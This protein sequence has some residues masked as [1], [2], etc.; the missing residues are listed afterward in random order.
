MRGAVVCSNQIAAEVGA[1]IIRRGGN[2]VDSAIATALSLCVVDPANCGVGG[3]GGYMLVQGGQG[4]SPQVVD[5]NAQV[6]KNFKST[7]L[8]SN[9]HI[10]NSIGGA[11]SVSMP[12]V[13]SGLKRAHEE[14]GSMPFKE[15]C[16]KP[17]EIARDGFVIGENLNMALRWAEGRDSEFSESFKLIFAPRGEWLTLGDVLV[18]SDLSKTLEKIQIQLDDYFY[19]GEFA[20]QTSKYIQQQGGWLELEHFNSFASKTYSAHQFSFDEYHIYGPPPITSGYG[21]VCDALDFLSKDDDLFENE[22][23]YIFKVSESL[24]YG[25]EKKK[26]IF[27]TTSNDVTQHTTHFCVSDLSGMM[28]SCTF[29][30][31]PLWFGSGMITPGTGVVLNCA[32][33]LFRKE[34]TSGQWLCVTNL[35]PNIMHGEEGA[36]LA[37]GAP[38]GLRIPAIVL[39]IILEMTKGGGNLLKAINKKRVSVSPI[40]ELELEDMNLAKIHHAHRIF[41]EEYFGPSSAILRRGNGDIYVGT[42]DRFKSGVA[43]I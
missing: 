13:L 43:V 7:L 25:W 28:V 33:N 14:F 40:G 20:L 32:A 38:G 35:S 4:Q 16:T 23:S 17:I 27:A 10:S 19:T 22:D 15:L 1:D 6:P 31:G 39:Q 2:A 41:E 37:S 26:S 5:F 3:Y 9:N 29:T 8:N 21:V 24:R 42:D 18:Q 30:H 34:L 11:S 36:R 12:M